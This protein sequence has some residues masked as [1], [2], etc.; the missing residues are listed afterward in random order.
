MIQSTVYISMRDDND[1]N[2]SYAIIAKGT[3]HV[4]LV[5]RNLECAIFHYEA[6][7]SEVSL[8]RYLLLKHYS[9]ET[10][11]Y[12]DFLKLIGKMC[13]KPAASKYF[14]NPIQEDNRM[15]RTNTETEHMICED[16][17][18]VFDERLSAFQQFMEQNRYRFR[19]DSR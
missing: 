13:K 9:N 7:K 1:L 12:T 16:E 17:C 4:L 18:A 15:V 10:S 19:L 2:C 8:D 11:A 5:L 3:A 14:L 6:Q